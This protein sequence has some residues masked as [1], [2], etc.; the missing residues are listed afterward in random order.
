MN[1]KRK[2]FIYPICIIFSPVLIPVAL[3]VFAC[4][5]LGIFIIWIVE[6]CKQEKYITFKEI[7]NNKDD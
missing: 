2:L 7:Y 5:G 3:S 4:M 1:L 6:N